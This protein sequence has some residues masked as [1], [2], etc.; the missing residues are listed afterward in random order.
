M[1]GATN[2]CQLR[3]K[4]SFKPLRFNSKSLSLENAIGFYQSLDNDMHLWLSLRLT[5]FLIEG[6]EL[7]R[8]L[9][10][11]MKFLSCRTAVYLY[12]VSVTHPFLKYELKSLLHRT[13]CIYETL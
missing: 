6:K 8:E 3:H 4:L 1:Q 11:V 2:F 13:V 9:I 5:I 12:S 7:A 10:L